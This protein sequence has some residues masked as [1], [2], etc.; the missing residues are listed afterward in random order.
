MEHW[1]QTIKRETNEKIKPPSITSSM[2]KWSIKNPQN[3]VAVI[4]P[5]F[6]DVKNKPLAK[7]GASGAKRDNQYWLMFAFTPHKIPQ[8]IVKISID[9]TIVL[10]P[11]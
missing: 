11:K 2:E 3:A 6:A 5:T 10:P 8:I 1:N 7:S 4:V 9:S